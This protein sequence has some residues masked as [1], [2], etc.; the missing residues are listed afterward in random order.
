MIRALYSCAAAATYV[1]VGDGAWT[2]RPQLI[3]EALDAVLDEPLPLLAHCSFGPIQARS[4]FRVT[5]ALH[6]TT[7]PAWLSMP[8]HAGDGAMPQSHSVPRALP[9]SVQERVGAGFRVSAP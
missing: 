8:T 3:I 7:T 4:N 9:P 2:P 6:Q 5:R 1:P